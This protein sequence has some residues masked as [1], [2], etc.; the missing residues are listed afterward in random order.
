MRVKVV[1]VP[2]QFHGRWMV[3]DILSRLSHIFIKTFPN[4]NS[5]FV[6]AAVWN[7]EYGILEA[8]L[9]HVL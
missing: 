5:H 1:Q 6:F 7:I 9:V 3:D 4:I 8:D 2:Y